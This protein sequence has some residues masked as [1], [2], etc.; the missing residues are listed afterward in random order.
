MAQKNGQEALTLAHEGENYYNEHYLDMQAFGPG[1][2]MAL[3]YLAEIYEVLGKGVPLKVTIQMDDRN[4][5]LEGKFTGYEQIERVVR[6]MLEP[7]FKERS[8][9]YY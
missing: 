4:A 1:V 7:E 3:Q 9:R 2:F 6:Q 5:V 8:S